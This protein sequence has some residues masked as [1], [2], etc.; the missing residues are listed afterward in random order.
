MVFLTAQYLNDAPGFYYYDNVYN[1]WLPSAGRVWKMGGNNTNA[2]SDFIGS[3]N[4]ADVVFKRDNQ[5]SG[6]ISDGNT[7][8][9]FKTLLNL[10]YYP[11]LR[12]TAFGVSALQSFSGNDNTATGY[13]S[14][15][16]YS[17]GSGNTA[18]G[19]YSLNSSTNGVFGYNS[20]LGFQT[21]SKLSNG[22]EN[23]AMGRNALFNLTYGSGNIA[24][25]AYAME[26]YATAAFLADPADTSTGIGKAAMRNLLDGSYGNLAVGSYAMEQGGGTH[27]NAFGRYALQVG[28]GNDNVAIGDEAM[29]NTA[30]SS[31]NVAIGKMAMNRFNGNENVAIG[32]VVMMANNASGQFNSAVGSR[33]LGLLMNG[34]GN[35][36]MG[37]NAMS[38]LQNGAYNTAVGA[39]TFATT[40]NFQYATAIG[41]GATVTAS[42][43]MRLGNA[44][45]ASIGGIVGWTTLSD[46][47]FKTNISEDVKGLEFVKKLRPVTY[48]LD[49]KA[50]ADFIGSKHASEVRTS[51]ESG[52]I[53][54]EVEAAAKSCGFVF[55]GVDAPKNAKDAYGLRYDQFVVPL[56]KAVQ[57][58]QLTIE[59]QQRE[60]AEF[61]A[62]LQ[63]YEAVQNNLLKRLDTIEMRGAAAN[64][65]RLGK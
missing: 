39:N 9:G 40:G 63:R 47:R 3:T 15:S 7:A 5:N 35:T 59:S 46:G 20:C 55:S 41:A 42:D 26:N 58:Q 22:D 33:A 38:Q 50:F 54:Q 6:L 53:A 19:A 10:T 14:M 45:T 60:I 31:Q 28:Y 4:A 24:L 36:V 51:K 65:S 64:N 25:G 12:S 17:Y 34:D 11:S 16:G 49:R 52:F 61:K 48:D 1:G 13:Q 23:V 29:R 8:F 37:Y 30:I 21:L 62:R 2:A 27:N 43:Q 44:T 57:E 32:N 56:V 18:V